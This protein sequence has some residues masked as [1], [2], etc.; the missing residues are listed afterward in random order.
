MPAPVPTSRLHVRSGP[1][2]CRSASFLL[3]ARGHAT[4]A[5]QG[6]SPKRL[7]TSGPRQ[8]GARLKAL[9]GD[10][11][12]K[13]GA[14]QEFA[15]PAL[16]SLGNEP[17]SL[18]SAGA[19]SS[20]NGFFSLSLAPLPRMR[21]RTGALHITGECILN[22]RLRVCAKQQ[23]GS[24]HVAQDFAHGVPWRLECVAA[25]APHLRR[26]RR[27]ERARRTHAAAACECARCTC[28]VASA[29]C[30]PNLHPDA[31]AG[32]PCHGRKLPQSPELGGMYASP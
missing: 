23:P 1:A 16:A 28:R 17:T 2:R 26:N 11:S 30:A 31:L 20:A 4:T 25:C 15:A 29:A 13:R 10:R 22:S 3:V 5:P 21:L 19:A 9:S 12:A 18:S 14:S 24:P 8:S 6:A 32:E 27:L 7:W